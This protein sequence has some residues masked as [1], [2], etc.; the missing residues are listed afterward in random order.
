L[1]KRW[2]VVGKAGLL[3]D[4]FGGRGNCRSLPYAPRDFLSSLVALANFVRLSLRKAAYVTSCG[5]AM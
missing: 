3:G 2:I 5:T 1:L 4:L